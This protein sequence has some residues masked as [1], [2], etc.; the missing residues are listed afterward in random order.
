MPCCSGRCGDGRGSGRAR[1]VAARVS[2][3]P[4]HWRGAFLA[5]V[6]PKRPWTRDMVATLARTPCSR[7]QR[8]QRSSSR[9]PGWATTWARI[10]AAWSGPIR[11]VPPGERPGPGGSG[12]ALMVQGAADRAIADGEAAGHLDLAQAALDGGDDAGAELGGVGFRHPS[13]PGRA[14]TVQPALL[15]LGA[16]D[17]GGGHGADLD[18]RPG[19]S[20]GHGPGDRAN[21]DLNMGRE[22]AQLEP[23]RQNPRAGRSGVRRCCRSGRW[24]GG[25]WPPGSR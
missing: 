5:T 6:I 21:A 11:A 14:I 23:I 13:L 19:P 3:R 2:P 12:P 1:P 7:C 25:R 20:R 24:A 18:Q 9:M 17:P 15:R 4:V 8:S 10:A 22:R 16:A